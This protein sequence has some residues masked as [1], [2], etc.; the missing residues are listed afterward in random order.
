MA[1]RASGRA[2]RQVDYNE[3]QAGP[4]GSVPAWTRQLDDGRKSAGPSHKE[5]TKPQP[6]KQPARKS[7]PA[8][9]GRGRDAGI[10]RLPIGELAGEG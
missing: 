6:A 1:T 10:T 4:H 9:A 5:N 7:A 2:H 3:K 8:V